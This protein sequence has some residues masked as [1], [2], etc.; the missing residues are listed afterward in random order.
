MK[1]EKKRLFSISVDEDKYLNDNQEYINLESCNFNGLVC[2]RNRELINNKMHA[3]Q[4]FWRNKN[5]QLSIDELKEA[6]RNTT[7]LSQPSC[8]QCAILFRSVITQSMENIH[9]DLQ[10]MSTG[11]FNG[12]SYKSNYELATNVLKEF[13]DAI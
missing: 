11:F 4:N 5:Y 6:Y 8:Q 10:K 12:N 7:E 2:K 1:G 9:K 13:K 3:S